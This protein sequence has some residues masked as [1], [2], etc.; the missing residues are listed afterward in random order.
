MVNVAQN[1]TLNVRTEP[2]YKAKKISELPPEAYYNVID[3]K[4]T[5]FRTKWIEREYLRGESHFGVTPD[6]VDGY[7]NTGIFIEEYL[8]NTKSM[9]PKLIQKRSL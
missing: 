9:I 8:K 7:C 2:N 4:K 1:D 6:N 3:Y 5:G